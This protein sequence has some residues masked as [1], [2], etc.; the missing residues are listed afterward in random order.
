MNQHLALSADSEIDAFR[1]Y[2]LPETILDA[3]VDAAWRFVEYFTAAIANDHTRAA[4]FRAAGQFFAWCQTRGLALAAVAPVH[5]AAYLK[6]RGGAVATIKQ[7]RAA[8][9]MLFDHLVVGQI[10]SRNPVLEVKTPRQ[11]LQKGKTPVLDTLQL[12]ELY[13][14]FEETI[15][16]ASERTRVIALR[17][18]AIT[19][20]MLYTFGRVSA[21]AGLRLRDYVQMGHRTWGLCL[22]EKNGNYL[23][24]PSHHVL[25]EYLAEYIEAAGIASDRDLPLFRAAAPDRRLTDRPLKQTHVFR[26]IRRRAA[27]VGIAPDRICCHSFRAT[28]ITIYLCNGGD[29]A[30]AQ[31]IAGHASINTTR[32]FYDHTDNAVLKNEIE[33]IRI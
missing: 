1:A 10:V 26:M 24:I 2:G 21:V 31:T 14:Y 5:V 13:Q 27:H 6:Q 19:A 25:D 22:Q 7:H 16:T 18:R 8:L 4:Y 28:G 12:Q 3:G 15:R 33:R 30:T 9:K 32:Q 23:E 11:K 17:D 20:S 29:L